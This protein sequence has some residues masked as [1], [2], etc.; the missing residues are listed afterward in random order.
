MAPSLEKDSVLLLDAWSTFSD[1]NL[2][3]VIPENKTIV[4][5]HIPEGTTGM[6]QPWDVFG[7]RIYKNFTKHISD[8]VLLNDIDVVLSQRDNIIK[9]QSLVY[10]Q[11]CSPRYESLFK[12]SWFKVSIRAIKLNPMPS[13]FVNSIKLV[14]RNLSDNCLN[15]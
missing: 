6:I 1:E 9:L 14:R 2:R 7:F 15:L 12:Y 10:N 8:F 5:Q 13:Q 3:A 11:M 4:I